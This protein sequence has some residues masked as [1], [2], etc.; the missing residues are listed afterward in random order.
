MIT[1]VTDDVTRLA[2]CVPEG[3]KHVHV[4]QYLFEGHGDEYVLVD[5]GSTY[6]REGSR[7]RSAVGR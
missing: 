1:H 7:T 3:E 2:Q 4:A 6:G 5:T